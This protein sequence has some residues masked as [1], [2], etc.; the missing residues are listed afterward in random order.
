[1]YIVVFVV[2]KLSFLKPFT[3]AVLVIIK[4]TKFSVPL[5]FRYGCS[6]LI[7]CLYF[8][9]F[10]MFKNVVHSLEPGETPSNSASHQAPN[11]V[12]RS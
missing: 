5:R 11:Y 12:Q 3:A 1:M 7:F 9:I 2:I 4:F 10:A 8:I 6:K